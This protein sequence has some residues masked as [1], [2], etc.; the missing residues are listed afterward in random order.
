MQEMQLR[1]RRPA[2]T[3]S[4][5]STLDNANMVAKTEI[6]NNTAS[7]G[8]KTAVKRKPKKVTSM[9]F[10]DVLVL[11]FASVAS[12]ARDLSRF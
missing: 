2:A 3:A 8:L 12:F 7:N 4:S 5:T 1:H 10:T 9:Y 6:N 11:V